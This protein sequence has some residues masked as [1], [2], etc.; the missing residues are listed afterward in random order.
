MIGAV[1]IN[2]NEMICIINVVH[3]LEYIFKRMSCILIIPKF[4]FLYVRYVFLRDF[5]NQAILVVE[6]I[7]YDMNSF[8]PFYT[9]I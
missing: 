5:C 7:N 2:H 6:I 1:R 4:Y 8:M 9:A 3:N